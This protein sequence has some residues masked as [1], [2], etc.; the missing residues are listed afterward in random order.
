[1]NSKRDSIKGFIE[2]KNESE[3]LLNKIKELEEQ[4][5]KL[6]KTNENLKGDLEKQ[7]YKFN[8]VNIIRITDSLKKN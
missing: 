3:E 6:K 1:M 2:D 4:N 5:N 8:K 7:K